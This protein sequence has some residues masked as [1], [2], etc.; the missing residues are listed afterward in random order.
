[1]AVRTRRDAGDPRPEP[2][3]FI[4]SPDA[5]S[6]DWLQ[7]A[8]AAGG[9]VQPQHLAAE[10]AVAP[11]GHGTSGTTVRVHAAYD[12]GAVAAPATMIAKIGFRPTAAGD[13]VN[14]FVREVKAYQFFGCEPPFLVPKTYYAGSDAAGHCNLL[15]EDLSELG[16]PGDQIA[17]CSTADAAAVV[18]ELAKL[19]RAYWKSPK[20][21]QL[22]WLQDQ[23]GLLPAYPTG[24]DI[25]GEWLG[26]R[27]PA[28][29]VDIVRAFAPLAGRWLAARPANWTLIHSDPRVDNVIFTRAADGRTRACLIDWQ[30]ACRGDPQQDVAYFLSGSVSPDDRRA[31]ERALIADHVRTIAEVDPG[32]TLEAA[33]EAYRFNM[34]S[35]LWLTVVACAFI[36]RT[37]HNARLIEA[38]LARNVAAIRDWDALAVIEESTR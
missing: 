22:D 32:Y 38:L 28:G 10:P 35:G 24:A 3:P 21:D 13:S 27:I 11:I 1:M 25:I 23:T 16:E 5:I 18:Q 8:F 15:L 4:A 26:G 30:G 2:P 37:E 36:Q 31:C 17:G 29:E 6:A 12:G 9:R 20:L 14:A 7:R 33:L 19:H 34:A